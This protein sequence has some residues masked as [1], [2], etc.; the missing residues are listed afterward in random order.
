M[1]R[2]CL[3]LN[4]LFDIEKQPIAINTAV[5]FDTLSAHD[6]EFEERVEDL[7]VFQ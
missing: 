5:I 3:E 2:Y 4:V 7:D 6:I 1:H